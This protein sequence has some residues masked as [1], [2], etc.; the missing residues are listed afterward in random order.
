VPFSYRRDLD[1][2]TFAKFAEKNF[3]LPG[4]RLEVVPVRKYV[5]GA[6]AAH[7]LGYVGAP[8]DV[9]KL[10]DVKDFDFYEPDMQG[11]TNIESVMDDVLQGKPGKRIL[12]KNG[13][14][15]IQTGTETIQPTP[16]S[17]V[18]L[19]IDARMQFIVE[20]VLRSVGRAACVVVDPNCGQIL[21]MASVPSYDP[22]NFGRS[23]SPVD[24]A[25]LRNATFKIVTALAGLT[26]GLANAK[27]TCTGGVLYGNTYMHCWGVHG[28]QGLVEA[29]KNSCDAYFYQFGNAAGIDAI[30]RV[31]KGLGIGQLTDVELTDEDPGLL[32]SPE[33]LQRTKYERWS[34]GQ[35]ANTSIGQGYVLASPLQMAMA[36]ATVANGG[37]CYTADFDLS[38]STT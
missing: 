26:K 2:A 14:N 5:Y 19:T 32:P 23:I 12:N 6:L 37:I 18:Y 35:T 4:V 8:E 28:R 24:W 15:Q 20:S 13:K 11:K 7:I 34:Q 21:A 10:R 17:N 29:I 31:G 36:A 22:N 25:A 33:W 9:S 30:D 1:F 27:F 3:G 38:N 16:G